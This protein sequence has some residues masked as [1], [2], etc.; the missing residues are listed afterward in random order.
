M[1]L[2]STWKGLDNKYQSIFDIIEKKLSPMQNY[3]AY[4][5]IIQKRVEKSI[6][7][8]PFLG[9]VTKELTALDEAHPN[10]LENGFICLSKFLIFHDIVLKKFY[11]PFLVHDPVHDPSPPKDQRL[12]NI[13]SF[14]ESL[15][16][17]QNSDVVLKKSMKIESSTDL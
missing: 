15:P 10:F 7:S 16:N 13:I 2:K 9:I 12:A 5:K 1:R 4:R 3:S 17:S 11:D 8:I 14:I 6:P